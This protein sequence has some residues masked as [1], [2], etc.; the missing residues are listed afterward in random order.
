[1]ERNVRGD[2]LAKIVNRARDN[3]NLARTHEAMAARATTPGEEVKHRGRARTAGGEALN[4]VYRLEGLAGRLDERAGRYR[5][6]NSKRYVQIRV[7]CRRRAA[8]LREGA[9]MILGVEVEGERSLVW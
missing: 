2:P 4:A 9:G 3:F 8:Q 6:R 7:A 1:M 5:S